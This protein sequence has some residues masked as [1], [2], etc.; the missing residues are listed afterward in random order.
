MSVVNVWPTM[1]LRRILSHTLQRICT[2]EMLPLQEMLLL[3]QVL[4]M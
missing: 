1:A 3:G 4:A 2:R